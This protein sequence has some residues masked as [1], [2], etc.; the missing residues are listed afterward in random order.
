M[1]ATSCA[2]SDPV[3]APCLDTVKMPA[4]GICDLCECPFE[5]PYGGTMTEGSCCEACVEM[6]AAILLTSF[7]DLVSETVDLSCWELVEDEE[8]CE[9]LKPDGFRGL[10]ESH[11]GNAA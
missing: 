8:L 11:G 6:A 1:L 3:S 4:V 7:G 10:E 2:H 5:A 9:Q